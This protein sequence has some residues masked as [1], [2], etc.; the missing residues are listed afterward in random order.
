MILLDTHALLWMS[1]DP[2]Q[3]SPKARNAIRQARQ[4]SGV[5]IAAITFWELAWLAHNGRIIVTGSLETFLRE[6]TARVIVKP[7]TPEIAAQA[8]RLPA[9]FPKDPA[10]RQIAAT[11]MLESIPLITADNEIRRSKVVNTIW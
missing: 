9:T 6:T 5:A 4:S 8:V 10:D 7:L 11:A 1:S 2:K 3:L